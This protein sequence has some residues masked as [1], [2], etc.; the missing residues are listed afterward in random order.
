VIPGAPELAPDN[1][2]SVNTLGGWVS[3]GSI[4][5]RLDVKYILLI[6][7]MSVNGENSVVIDKKLT[8]VLIG[9]PV[10]SVEVINAEDW[11]AILFEMLI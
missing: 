8:L 7:H 4:G 9:F 10:G 5:S 6:G 1:V 3:I 11:F 2:E